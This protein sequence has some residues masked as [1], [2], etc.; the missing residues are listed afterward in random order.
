MPLAA[1]PQ[2]P[3]LAVP[4]MAG[5]ALVVAF[6]TFKWLSS[7]GKA[8]TQYGEVGGAAAGFIVTFGVLAAAYYTLEPRWADTHHLK[9]QVAQQKRVIASSR[10]PKG[11][12]F[13]ASYTPVLDRPHGIAFAY[14]SRWQKA[15]SLETFQQDPLS[16]RDGQKPVNLVVTAEPL[17]RKS[18]S[19][20]QVYLAAEKS[21][22][23]VRQVQQKLG[24]ALTSK[25]AVLEVN[26]RE[27]LRVF[28]AHGE[29]TRDAIY[30]ASYQLLRASLPGTYT[31][32]DDRMIGG[33]PSL[34]AEHR[35]GQSAGSLLQFVTETYV[36][37]RGMLISLT[38]TGTSGQRAKLNDV[39]ERVINTLKFLPPQT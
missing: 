24:V 9:Q 19:V 25:T 22:I 4:V 38:F 26:L 27:V 17:Q 13:P 7:S 6:V 35:L 39:R 3:L 34:A 15:F 18:Y 21:G 14:P 20:R 10:L 31:R 12:V 33:I 11:F 37:P 23:P 5:V 32:E 30:D 8:K 1:D 28:G 16:V 36:A 2:N 29:S